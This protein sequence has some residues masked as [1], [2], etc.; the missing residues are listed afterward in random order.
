VTYIEDGR[1][2]EYFVGVHRGDRSRFETELFRPSTE[3]E[4]PAPQGR[5]EHVAT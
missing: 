2:I 4:A 5:A 1:A 3:A